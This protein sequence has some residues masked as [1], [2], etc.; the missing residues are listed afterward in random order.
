MSSIYAICSHTVEIELLVLCARWIAN[1]KSDQRIRVLL[2]LQIDWDFLIAIA[3][4][5]RVLPLLYHSLCR[6]SPGDVPDKA[7]SRLQQEFSANV[8]RNLSLTA[9]LLQVLDIFAANEIPAIPYKGPILAASIY[10]DVSLRQFGDL[11]I[12]V[13]EIDKARARELLISRGYRL[14]RRSEKEDTLVHHARGI[15]LEL[16]SHI[17]SK[18]HP[19]QISLRRLWQNLKVFSIGGKSVQIHAPE[20]LLLILCIHGA[21]H[22]WARLGWLC[23]IAEIA[24]YHELNW[25][26]VIDDATKLGSR[27]ILF[28][29]LLLAKDILGAELP[30]TALRGIEA[31]RAL[32]Q[33]SEQVTWWLFGVGPVPME[34]GEKEPRFIRQR[35]F[36]MQRYFVRLRE[37]RR[38]KFRIA[39]KQA[40]IYI[41]L[42]L[43]G[44]A[45]PSP[46]RFLRNLFDLKDS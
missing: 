18:H 5:H 41:S 44:K 1:E 26:R 15:N 11:D 23:D 39:I 27:R 8:K 31:D 43:R 19:I 33:L 9:E 30:M 22:C 14:M 28:L 3:D 40:W 21:R 37:R 36:V 17:T 12:I 45:R 24:R 4:Q 46:I 10:G 32:R 13:H 42:T 2:Q 6:I 38:D 29:G 25:A 16:H 20:D 35:Y 7:M 34:F